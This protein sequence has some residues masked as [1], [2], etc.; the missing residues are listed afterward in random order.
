MRLWP[1]PAMVTWSCSQCAFQKTVRAK[2]AGGQAHLNSVALLHML[3][4][5]D[6]RQY[7][8]AVGG[9]DE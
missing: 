9:T 7:D 1:K 8:G 6:E 3:G 4:H 2:A 5:R